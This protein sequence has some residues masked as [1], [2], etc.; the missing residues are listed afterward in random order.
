MK[1]FSAILLLALLAGCSREK[2]PEPG[3]DESTASVSLS[4]TNC[5][6]GDP[7]EL[8][9]SV[10]HPAGTTANLT[11]FDAGEDNEYVLQNRH[12]E[13]IGKTH[14]QTD[15]LYEFIPFATGTVELA[16]NC[17]AVTFTNGLREATP[18]G[19]V[20]LTVG[21]AIP[22][23]AEHDLADIKPPIAPQSDIRKIL[24]VMSGITVAALLAAA[25]I[26]WL[27]TRTKNR[28]VKPEPLPPPAHETALAALTE[29]ERRGWIEAGKF[30]LFFPELSD[31]L[32]RYLGARFD[33][34]APESTTEEIVETFNRTGSIA[35]ARKNNLRDFMTQ[36]DLIKF[37]RG[38]AGKETMRQ[39]LHQI[40][41]FVEETKET[42]QSPEVPS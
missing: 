34:H 15:F 13:P 5:L 6:I 32:R 18:L 27:T 30:H 39:A 4:V 35:P 26:W 9:I 31:I 41:E 23:G 24:L 16:T 37:A 28:P 40:T 38:E 2:L 8:A 42:T 25:L 19:G 3:P 33:F 20:T 12:T 11:E 17:Y 7:V 10:R 21:S 14:L 36:C 1:H 22:E 29:L